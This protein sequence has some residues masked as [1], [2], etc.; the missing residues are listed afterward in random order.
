MLSKTDDPKHGGGEKLKWHLKKLEEFEIL[1]DY[2]YF[3]RVRAK[4]QKGTEL[5]KLTTENMTVSVS[6]RHVLRIALKADF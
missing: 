5:E 3:S 2:E 1:G 4:G 6:S